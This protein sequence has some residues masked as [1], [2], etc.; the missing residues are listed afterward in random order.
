MESND[1]IYAK[2]Q[3]HLDNQAVGFPATKSGVEIKILKRIFSPEEAELTT[4]LSYKFEPF[5]KIYQSVQHLVA[6]PDQLETLLDHLQTKGGVIYKIIEGKKHYCCV[7]FVVGM[8]EFQLNRLSPEFIEEVDQYTSDRAFGVEFLSTRLP[9]MRTIPISKSI[10]PKHNASSFDET[11]MLLEKAGGPF[12]I[13]ECICRK[14]RTIQ[15]RSCKTTDR[16]ETCL[17]IGFSA[18]MAITKNVGRKISK[19]EAMAI[20]EQNQSDGLVLQPSNTIEPDFICSC[21]GCCC[22][23]LSMHKILPKPLDYWATNF[24]AVVDTQ[25][26]QGCGSCENRCQVGAVKV[27]EKEQCAA[28]NLDRCIGCGNC[29]SVCPTESIFLKKKPIET[30]PPQTREELYNIIMENKKG[31]LG[32]LMLTGKLFYDAFRTRQTHLLK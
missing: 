31:K 26:C 14:K 25:T 12:V 22:G 16:K 32:K 11:K 7:P 15:G 20:L 28:V 5:E 13:F 30:I 3:K 27:S 24:Y 17:G 10:H 1:Q 21:C 23:L 19:S 4:Y 29:V 9:Q 2:L 6:S 18:Q 8:Y